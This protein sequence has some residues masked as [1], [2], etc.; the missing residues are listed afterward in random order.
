MSRRI[1]THYLLVP[2]VE[3][4]MWAGLAWLAYTFR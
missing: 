4:V 1:E 3:V 2:V